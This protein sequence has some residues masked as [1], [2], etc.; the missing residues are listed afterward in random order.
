MH[1]MYFWICSGFVLGVVH[2]YDVFWDLFGLRFGSDSCIRC[3]LGFVQASLRVCFVH[4][5]YIYIYMCSV[6]CMRRM[7]GCFRLR[8][9]SVLCT[10]CSFGFV[11]ASVCVGAWLGAGSLLCMQ[12]LVGHSRC[13]FG[14]G[15]DS[16]KV[17]H[18][19]QCTGTEH[20]TKT[21][22]SAN[23]FGYP[24]W[25]EVE[26]AQGAPSDTQNGLYLSQLP[27]HTT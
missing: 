25:G 10:R 17:S 15:Q 20:L 18:E 3:I 27:F 16:L 6:S 19:L 9:G 14:L 11:Q 13:S 21:Y 5:L 22:H 23:R 24:T 12:S 8:P 1:T 2:A 26:H 7:F 4:T